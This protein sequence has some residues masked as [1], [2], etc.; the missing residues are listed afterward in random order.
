MLGL[1]TGLR[2]PRGAAPEALGRESATT[3][4]T[5]SRSWRAYVIQLVLLIV[6]TGLVS[7]CGILVTDRTPPPPAYPPA[8][9]PSNVSQVPN[10]QE[11]HDLAVA[12]V[13]FDP[14]L[15][16]RQIVMGRPYSLLVA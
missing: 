5:A 1:K 3:T 10:T 8:P 6:S 12:A 4:G 11:S 13:D 2:A 7:G 9:R 15:D 14:A 16:S